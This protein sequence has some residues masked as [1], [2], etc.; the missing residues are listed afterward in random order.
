MASAAIARR[1]HAGH[2][3]YCPGAFRGCRR[4]ISLFLVT[5]LCGLVGAVLLVA[6]KQGTFVR[7]TTIYFYARRRHRHQQGHVG[8]PLRPPGRR[9]ERPAV[10]DRGVRVRLSI[11]NDYVAAPHQGSQARL[12]REGYVGAASSSCVPGTD[13]KGSREPVARAT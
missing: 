4:Q 7:H 10:T 6:Y 2:N 1:K 5:A 8:A 11:I 12:T 9:G 13:P 3:R